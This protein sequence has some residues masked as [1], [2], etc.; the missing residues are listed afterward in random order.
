MA[1]NRHPLGAWLRF[2]AFKCKANVSGSQALQYR[3]LGLP[4]PIFQF[5][6]TNLKLF[7]KEN[8]SPG[9]R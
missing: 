2:P 9:P 3:S 6:T 1:D 5:F 4:L 7:P 8:L